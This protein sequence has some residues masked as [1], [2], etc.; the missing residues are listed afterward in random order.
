MDDLSSAWRMVDSTE[1]PKSD[2][3]CWIHTIKSV[4]V[5]LEALGLSTSVP[6]TEPK[7]EQAEPKPKRPLVRPK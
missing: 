6:T 1:P 7:R 4:F 5:E 2:D 3:G